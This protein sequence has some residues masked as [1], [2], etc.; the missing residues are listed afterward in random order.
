V[1][2]ALCHGEMGR[3]VEGG[4]GQGFGVTR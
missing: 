3:E 2:G 1:C 4:Y